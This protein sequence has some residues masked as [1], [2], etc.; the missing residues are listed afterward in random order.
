[1][2]RVLAVLAFAACV[3]G[4]DCEDNAGKASEKKTTQVP[5][6]DAGAV[7]AT[8]ITAPSGCPDVW[9]IR[10]GERTI[11]VNQKGAM[12]VCSPKESVSGNTVVPEPHGK[13]TEDEPR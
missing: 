5:E 8:K 9:V 12:V 10:D 3:I 13:H 11:Y 1:M 7:S 4:A 6:K 2:K